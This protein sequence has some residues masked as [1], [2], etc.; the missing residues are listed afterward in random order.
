M[1]T[2]TANPLHSVK[3]A[4]W[5]TPEEYVEAARATL[6]GIDLDPASCE[7]AN[8]TVNAT[9]YF[10][11]DDHTFDEPWCGRVFLNPPKGLVGDF[12]EKLVSEWLAKNTT[13]AV[14]VGY[15]L[16]QLQV[17][18]KFEWSPLDF[19]ICFTKKRIRFV[20]PEGNKQSPTHSNYIAYLGPDPRKFRVAF[21]GFGRV[22]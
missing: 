3:S 17:L 22:L 15:S 14:W 6:G 20:S 2:Q 12:W 10:T 16:E 1:V 7:Y 5:Y 18:Q 8:R 11:K 21:E 9:Q 19:P 13:A 4:E